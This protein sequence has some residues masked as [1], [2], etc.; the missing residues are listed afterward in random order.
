[1]IKINNENKPQ[2][3]KDPIWFKEVTCPVCGAK[4]RTPRV[5]PSFLKVK[6]VDSDFHKTYEIVN[7]VLY[8]I[9]TCNECNYSARNSDYDKVTLEYHKEIIDLAMSIKNSKK[10]VIFKNEKNPSIEEVINKHLLAIYFYK[11]FKPENPS[12]IS[13]L[14]MHLVWIYRDAGDVAKEREYVKYAIEYYVKTYERGI[15]IPE[16]IGVPGIM[17]LIGDLNRRLENYSE[18]VQWFS[19]VVRSDMIDNYP[20]IKNLTYE[21]WEKINEARKHNP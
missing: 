13:G 18:A 8:A 3:E 21:A 14:Y 16:K 7:P 11:S 15:Q 20:N 19:K 4:H 10:N 17:Y 2:E 12:I 5:K 9:T 6:S 1:M